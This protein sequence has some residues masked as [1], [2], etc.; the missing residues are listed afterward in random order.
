MGVCANNGGKILEKEMSSLHIL[1]A[2]IHFYVF[3]LF[4]MCSQVPEDTKNKSER[5]SA[6]TP[7]DISK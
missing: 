6:V 2:R 4:Y 7:T 3:L 1:F 5:Q